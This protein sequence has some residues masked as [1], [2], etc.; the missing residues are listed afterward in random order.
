MNDKLQQALAKATAKYEAKGYTVTT[1]TTQLGLIATKGIYEVCIGFYEDGQKLLM[2]NH[3]NGKFHGKTGFWFEN[4]QKKLMKS[5]KNGKASGKHE[6]WFGNG[7]QSYIY[8]YINGK[9]H[10]KQYYWR[11]K[12]GRGKTIQ[13]WKNDK[14]IKF[15][16]Y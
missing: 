11:A 14:F 5:Y 9:K 15:I 6:G 7:Q 3:K 13:L 1:T 4:G 16:E 12:D 8:N 2:S 10:G